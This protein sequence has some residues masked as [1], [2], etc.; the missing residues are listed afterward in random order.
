MAF[1]LA[2]YDLTAYNIG[3]QPTLYLAAQG[4]EKV[5]TSIGFSSDIFLSLIGSEQ[6]NR[7]ISGLP[8]HFIEGSSGLETVDEL[9]AEGETFVI[10]APK[11]VET[12]TTD[13]V[14]QAADIMPEAIG[15]EIIDEACTFA[16]NITVS[17]YG[18]EK[19]NKNCKI[20]AVNNLSAEGYELVS[21]SASVVVLDIRTCQLKCTL[22]PGDRLV[23]DASTYTVLLNGENAIELQSGDWI[24]ELDRDTTDLSFIC[25]SGT[26]QLSAYITY[27]ER[28]L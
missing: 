24:D 15:Q 19:V 21:E 17:A 27:Q 5:T 10:L 3:G 9:V 14:T 7:S 20:G 11:F 1:N 4:A 2:R 13:G 22:K 8:C 25:S 16:G 18:A 28:Y 26:A 6:V 23:I 12:I